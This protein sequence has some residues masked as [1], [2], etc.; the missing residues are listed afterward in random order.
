MVTATG[1]LLWLF[2]ELRTVPKISSAAHRERAAGCGS[3]SAETAHLTL[4]EFPQQPPRYLASSPEFRDA[5]PAQC[6]AARGVGR[7]EVRSRR[8]ILSRGCLRTRRRRLRPVRATCAPP[9]RSGFAPAS[10]GQLLWAGTRASCANV[11]RSLVSEP[12]TKG[13]RA[14]TGQ[15]GGRARARLSPDRRRRQSQAQGEE[16]SRII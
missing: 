1:I 13:R 7:I 10:R 9:R 5:G 6:Y 15:V 16:A 8:R 12:G 4:G 11:A 2:V 3:K 14:R